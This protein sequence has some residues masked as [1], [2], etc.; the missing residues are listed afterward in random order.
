M[1]ITRDFLTCY[2]CLDYSSVI[3]H[4]RPIVLSHEDP[5]DCT[6]SLHSQTI[7][8]IYFNDHKNFNIN[9]SGQKL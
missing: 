3:K 7:Y 4:S 9:F 5:R 8:S 6:E 1:H 2:Y